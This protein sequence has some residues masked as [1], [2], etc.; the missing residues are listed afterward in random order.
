LL[1]MNELRFKTRP[2]F[3][4]RVESRGLLTWGYHIAFSR[5]AILGTDLGGVCEAHEAQEHLKP[6]N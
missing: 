5:L 1:Q 3:A 4:T 6:K 2:E